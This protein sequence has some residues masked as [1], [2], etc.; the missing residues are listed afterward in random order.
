M[1]WDL[2]EH[3]V[4]TVWKCEKGKLDRS[5]ADANIEVLLNTLQ[6]KQQE[7]TKRLGARTKRSHT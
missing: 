5:E 3:T 4:E 6:V 1:H 2:L 7:R